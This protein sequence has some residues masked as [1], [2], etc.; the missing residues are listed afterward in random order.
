MVSAL[1]KKT[2]PHKLSVS[3]S[4]PQCSAR[5]ADIKQTVKVEQRKLYFKDKNLFLKV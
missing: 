5:G 4:N 1:R 3:Q 2:L